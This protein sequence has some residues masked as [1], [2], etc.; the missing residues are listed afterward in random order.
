MVSLATGLARTELEGWL[1]LNVG[2]AEAE[3]AWRL[4][5]ALVEAERDAV[6]DANAALRES[7]RGASKK[8]DVETFSLC[9]AE[10][11]IRQWSGGKLPTAD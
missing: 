3:E 5:A 1:V 7:W 10:Q 11:L 6:I 2:S 9:L 4:V 8:Y